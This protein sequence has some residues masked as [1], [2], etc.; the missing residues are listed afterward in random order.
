[1]SSGIAI[2][3]EIIIVLDDGTPLLDWDQGVGID[4]FRGEFIRYSGMPYSHPI[5]D[6]ELETLRRAG[7]V[8]SFDSQE[9]IFSTL[10]EVPSRD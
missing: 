3:R 4:L 7:R 8:I 10:P 9:V 5:Q 1:M 6:D 2:R